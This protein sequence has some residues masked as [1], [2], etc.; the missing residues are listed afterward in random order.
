M[1]GPVKL[2]FLSWVVQVYFQPAKNILLTNRCMKEISGSLFAI[3]NS[4]HFKQLVLD[5]SKHYSQVMDFL[6]V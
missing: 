5:A 6:F 4:D 3:T 1:N 2:S